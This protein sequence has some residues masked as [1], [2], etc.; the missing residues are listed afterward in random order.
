MEQIKKK[1]SFAENQLTVVGILLVA[2]IV[3]FSIFVKGFFSKMNLYNLFQQI[4]MI[5]IVTVGQ[6]FVIV[7]GCID[8]AQGATLGLSTVCAALVVSSQYGNGPAWLAII[9]CLAVSMIFSA[10]NGLLITRAHLTPFIVTLGMTSVIEAIALLTNNGADIYGLPKSIPNFAKANIGGVLPVMTIIMI[11]FLIAG[12]ILLGKTSFGRSVYATGSNIQAAKFSGI[13]VERVRF[14]VYMIS[15]LC[16]GAAAFIMLAKTSGGIVKSGSDYQMDAISGVVIGGGSLDGGRGSI[17]GA[18]IGAL[19]MVILSNGLQVA[20]VSPY[21]Q[22]L[23]TGVI[24]IGAVYIDM[25]RSRKS[26]Q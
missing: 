12:Y 4:T 8:L 7:A 14:L 25:L 5:A 6:T 23:I 19:I 26:G 1:R 22:Q 11:V 24:L 15:G 13:K 3:G 10:I 20:G 9:V 18:F 17:A 16:V 21:L 2:L